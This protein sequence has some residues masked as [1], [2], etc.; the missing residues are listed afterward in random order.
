VDGR[1]G[2]ER[3][4]I[5]EAI[6][7]EKHN[8][9]T[10]VPE[11]YKDATPLDQFWILAGANIAPINWILGALGIVLGLGFWDTVLVLAIGSAGRTCSAGC[12]VVMNDDRAV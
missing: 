9:I 7:V 12:P 5:E 8:A 1:P 6:H 3:A 4:E 2:R 10:P 11:E